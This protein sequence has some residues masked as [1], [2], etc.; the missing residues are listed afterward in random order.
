MGCWGKKDAGML[1]EQSELK[2]SLHATLHVG[3]VRAGVSVVGST[4]DACA[5]SRVML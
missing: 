3:H 2:L 5:A 1:T 4:T